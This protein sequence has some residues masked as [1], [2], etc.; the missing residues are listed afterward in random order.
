MEHGYTNRRGHRHL[1]SLRQS[2][3]VTSSRGVCSE[4]GCHADGG[5]IQY[6]A[7]DLPLW[8][9]WHDPKARVV[10]VEGITPRWRIEPMTPSIGASMGR[11]K[12]S[13]PGRRWVYITMPTTGTV[14]T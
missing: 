7:L 10:E 11:D 12:G 5:A 6:I 8:R 13:S 3:C 9:D 2:D 14:R 1:L 4:I